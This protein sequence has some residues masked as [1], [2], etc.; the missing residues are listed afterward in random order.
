MM[1]REMKETI[2][3]VVQKESLEEI[4]TLYHLLLRIPITN[5]MMEV[6][7]SAVAYFVLE[8]IQPR[9]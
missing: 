2:W 7:R 1:G 5:K 6:L 8:R 3:K 9:V 4:R